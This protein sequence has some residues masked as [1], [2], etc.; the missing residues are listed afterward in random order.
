M[1]LARANALCPGQPANPERSGDR[2]LD[3]QF[4]DQPPPPGI[5]TG[6]GICLGSG[7]GIG[8]LGTGAGGAGGPNVVAASAAPS[9]KPVTEPTIANDAIADPT[10]SRLQ[11]FLNV[12]IVFTSNFP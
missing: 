7:F 2:S 5:G 6:I 8:G 9:P 12:I 11:V 4:L 10:A 3:H 1:K